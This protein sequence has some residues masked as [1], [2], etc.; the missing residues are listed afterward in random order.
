LANLRV[1]LRLAED[2]ISA[3]DDFERQWDKFVMMMGEIIR[4][5]G[6][7]HLTFWDPQLDELLKKVEA[8][9]L[10]LASRQEL[11]LPEFRD[12]LAKFIRTSVRSYSGD[13][14]TLIGVF[15]RDSDGTVVVPIGD[16][17]EPT[18]EV[19]QRNFEINTDEARAEVVRRRRILTE[20]VR[21]LKV[22]IE[23]AER[24]WA[25][26]HEL[27]LEKVHATKVVPLL[28]SRFKGSTVGRIVWWFGEE[29]LRK[30]LLGLLVAGAGVAIPP[31]RHGVADLIHRLLGR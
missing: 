6:E 21:K 30:V 9:R 18:Y 20:D 12:P 2:V 27:E 25:E 26:E 16:D 14:W 29:P 10:D 11:V 7:E 28:W 3:L 24:V 8:I 15:A 31:I 4:L 13:L 19:S 17:G 22:M 1:Q 5:C 23:E